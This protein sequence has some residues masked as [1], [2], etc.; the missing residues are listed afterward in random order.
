[1]SKAIEDGVVDGDTINILSRQLWR[2]R[3]ELVLVIHGPG[4]LKMISYLD[5]NYCEHRVHVHVWGDW[6]FRGEIEYVGKAAALE[7]LTK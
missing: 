6:M 7:A 5:S 1:M 3:G 2:V 4:V